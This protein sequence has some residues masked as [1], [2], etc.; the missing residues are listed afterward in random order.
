MIPPGSD[1][2]DAKI[3]R[4]RGRPSIY[5]SEEAEQQQEEEE[6]E[7]AVQTGVNQKHHEISDKKTKKKMAEEE[8]KRFQEKEVDNLFTDSDYLILDI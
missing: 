4:G 6:V 1:G 2:K 3:V 7:Q 8:K 5:A